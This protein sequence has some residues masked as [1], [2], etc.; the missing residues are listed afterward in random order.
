MA[1]PTRIL[2]LLWSGDLGGAER[3]V[4]D[5]VMALPPGRF[6]ATVCFLSKAS[7]I[8]GLLTQAEVR[9][10]EIGLSNG[11]DLKGVLRFVRWL[12][13][14]QFDLVH[15]HLSTPWTRVVIGTARLRSAV[16][17]TE[18]NG[19]L[20]AN[21]DRWH[22][23]WSRLS[24]RYTDQFIAVS[25]SI[26]TLLV[27]NI[28]L[29][30][31]QI[32][33]VYNCVDS[34]RFPPLSDDRRSH[35]RRSLGLH[36]K[37]YVLIAVGHLDINKGFDRLIHVMVPILRERESLHLLLVGEGA[38]RH[39]LEMQVADLHLQ[40]QVHLLGE[41]TDVPGLLGA[42]DIL[43]MASRFESFGIVAAEA[44]MTGIPV[45][46]PDIAGLREVVDSG[47]TGF[48]IPENRLETDFPVTIARLLD[49]PELR[50]EM[51]KSGQQ[52][53]AALFGR[54]QGIRHV[55]DLYEGLLSK[56]GIK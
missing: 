28:G 21:L 30:P 5:L 31:G 8:G 18:H 33:V 32:A 43:V 2:Y 52:R 26:K 23:F 36:D 3:H 15:D 47:K 54:D 40:D 13:K 6:V 39:R 11:Y 19:H 42:A 10:A 49:D 16:V 25:Q 45:V 56:K 17:Y 44:M 48:L 4:Y 38:L 22:W 27:K 12:R 7:T 9:V 24:A 14:N 50:R 20:L 46:A 35:I 34:S 41:R 53:A 29:S 1:Y 55:V 37:H 51:G